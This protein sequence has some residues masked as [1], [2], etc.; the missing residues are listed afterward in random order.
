MTELLSICQQLNIVKHTK[1]T[2]PFHGL[3]RIVELS[4]T[5]TVVRTV[6][7]PQADPIRIAY[8][9][10]CQCSGLIPDKLF[11]QSELE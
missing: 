2:R 10:I 9:K 1:F 7:Q 6:D 4:K 11:G 5:D 8:N 3:Y